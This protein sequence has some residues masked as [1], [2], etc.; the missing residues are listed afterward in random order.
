MSILCLYPSI[1]IIRLEYRYKIREE[2][3]RHSG[4]L[5]HDEET[6]TAS[7]RGN[8]EKGYIE[9][10]GGREEDGKEKNSGKITTM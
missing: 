10:G 8:N 3:K 2:R 4:N 5:E 9:W 6:F 1:F 7:T